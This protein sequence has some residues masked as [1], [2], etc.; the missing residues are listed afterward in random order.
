MRGFGRLL[1]GALLTGALLTGCSGR[2]GFNPSVS[3]V[4]V[5]RDGAVSSALV[6]EYAGEDVDE[7]DL[8]QFLEAAVIRFNQLN[9]AEAL[10]VNKGGGQKLPAAL[11]SVKAE[12][13]TMKAVFDFATA[14]DLIAFGG[15]DE[16]EDTSNTL[17]ALEVKKVPDAAEAGWLTAAA[18]V[19]EDKSAVP[20]EEIAESEKGMVV[21]VEGGATLVCS[22]E[23]L[24]MTEGVEK[25]DAHTAAVPDGGKAFIVFK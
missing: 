21:S 5:A 2:G 22:G 8:R 11:Q 16:N 12:D 3:C 15:T 9:G 23:I 4:Y 10:A 17:T 19:K 7:K 24:Y 20:A 1:A 6:K 18:F 25:K 13:G 14:R